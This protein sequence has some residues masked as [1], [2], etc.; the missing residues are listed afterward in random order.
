[1]KCTVQ[2]AK[3][4]VKNLVRQRCVEEFNSDVKG[5]II[6][7][8]CIRIYKAGMILSNFKFSCNLFGIMSLVS[9]TNGIIG[10]VF[11]CRVVTYYCNLYYCYIYIKII[12]LSKKEI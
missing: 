12:R 5:L 8:F 9:S 6:T 11:I 4:P 1:M 10:A 7:A 3:S 2:E